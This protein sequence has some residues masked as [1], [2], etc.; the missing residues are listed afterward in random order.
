GLMSG[1]SA[2]GVDAALVQITGHGHGLKYELL[3]FEVR[4][5]PA[6]VRREIM[7]LSNGET[8]TPLRLADLDARLGHEFALAA[9][10]CLEKVRIPR[11]KL[12]F[13]ASH[14]QT[15]CHHPPRPKGTYF[16]PESILMDLGTSLQIG[17]PAFIAEHLQVPVISHFRQRDIAAGG[18]G[19]PLVPYIDRLLLQATNKARVVVN[20]GG[21]TNLTYLPSLESKEEVLAF[22]VGPGNMLMDTLVGMA[23][24]DEQQ[25]DK[26]GEMAARG[27]ADLYLLNNLGEHPFYPKPPPKSAG[28]E[29]FGLDY[30]KE[31]WNKAV[32]RGISPSNLMATVTKLTAMVLV[33]ALDHHLPTKQP[34]KEVILSGGGVRNPVLLDHITQ[35]LKGRCQIMTSDA[36][37]LPAK[38]KE[39]IAFAILGNETIF[40]QPTNLP[41]ATGAAGL[42]VLG[43]ITPA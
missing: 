12:D 20:I 33:H 11:E 8:C 14:G 19:A 24:Q 36:V 30:A 41:L 22:D 34:L 9:E 42:R 39:A 4:E 43:R 31:V 35:S 27:K 23:T 5:Y 3:H 15:I 25:Y 1:T 18:Q 16:I 7:N 2:D 28:R 38:A 40:N 37:G 29:E 13:A 17:D 21:I 32:Q 10:Q 26:N 6:H